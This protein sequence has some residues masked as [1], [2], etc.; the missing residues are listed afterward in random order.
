MSQWFFIFG[1]VL[2]CFSV[3]NWGVPA[4]LWVRQSVKNRGLNWS[5]RSLRSTVHDCRERV[6]NRRLSWLGKWRR[7][8]CRPWP[9][10]P[11]WRNFPLIGGQ[12]DD[13]ICQLFL[14]WRRSFLTVGLRVSLRRQVRVVMNGHKALRLRFANWPSLRKLFCRKNLLASESNCSLQV[15]WLLLEAPWTNEI[16]SVAIFWFLRQWL[17]RRVSFRIH[18]CRAE[19]VDNFLGFN[20][21]FVHRLMR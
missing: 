17:V 3:L 19:S 16:L 20:F 5:E 11:P 13:F 10:L 6:W 14:P 2:T 7:S 9:A 1:F 15:F 8:F 12:L 21:K 18:A 4:L